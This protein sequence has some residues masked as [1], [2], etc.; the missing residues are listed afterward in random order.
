MNTGGTEV[1]VQVTVAANAARGVRTVT[2]VAPAGESSSTPGPNNQLTLS[3]GLAI[4]DFPSVLVG[5]QLGT[6]TPAPPSVDALVAS[7]AVGVVRGT[8]PPT[9]Q[10]NTVLA[11]LIGVTVSGASGSASQTLLASAPLVGATRGP[12]T[13]RVEPAAWI[14]GQTG[15]LIVR[16]SVLPA[17]STVQLLPAS[18]VTLNGLPTVDADG[19]AIRQSMTVSAATTLKTLSVNVLK[20]DGTAVPSA[21]PASEPLFLW[22]SPGLPAVAS[23]ETIVARQGDKVDLLIRG[24]NLGDALRVTSDPNSGIDFA[25]DFTVNAAGTELRIQFSVRDDAPLGARVFRVVS[26]LGASSA[27]A[28]PANTFTV[29]P[30][31]LPEVV[32][33]EPILARQGDTVNLVIRG[34]NLDGA[35]QVTAEPAS[36]IELA[37]TFTVNAA[38][39]ELRIQIVVRSDAPLGARVIRVFTRFGGSSANASPANTFT[40]F[41]R[42]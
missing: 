33:L 10:G 15:V 19:A 27:T 38:G 20:P 1:R 9:E 30:A 29:F 2:V 36:G 14:P 31:E 6:P 17:G 8:P 40:V 18:A 42:I 28:T 25:P 35:L 32:S 39:T 41:P 23:L 16:G 7:S 34:T 5:V 4:F 12:V 11:Q 3:D 13:L 37:P 26:R 24:T 21:A 22:L